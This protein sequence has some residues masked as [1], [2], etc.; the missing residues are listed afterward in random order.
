MTSVQRTPWPFP[1]PAARPVPAGVRERVLR[2]PRGSR[3]TE[4][5]FRGA[6]RDTVVRAANDRASGIDEYRSPAVQSIR[7]DADEWIC[8]LR[9]YSV[10]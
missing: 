4:I 8:S 5:E 2:Q 6:D 1:T 10:D 7:R 3:L 9:Y